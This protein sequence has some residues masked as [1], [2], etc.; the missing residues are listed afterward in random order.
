L[1]GIVPGDVVAVMLPN[2]AHFPLA[3][4]ALSKI[5][6]T[7]VPVNVFYKRA[8]AGYLLAHS[9]ARAVLTTEAHAPLLREIAADGG[10]APRI[11]T[12]DGTI[13]GSGQTLD[14]LARDESPTSFPTD[15]A[16]LANIQYTSG[17]TGH[18]KGCML[19]NG[20]WLTMARELVRYNRLSSEDTMLTAQPFYYMDPQWNVVCALLTGCELVVLDRFHP[21]E[22]WRK[23]RQHRV[24]WFYCLGTMPLMLLNNPPAPDD[25]D[26]RVRMVM[27]SAIPPGR[28][29]EIEQ[30]WGAPW[31]EA[32]GMT[33]TGGDLA[34]PIEEHDALV[35]S[36]CIGRPLP[37]REARIVGPD[38]AELPAD[39]VGEMALRGARMMN[40][41][42][43][44][45]E[46][47]REIMRGGW[48]HTGDLARRDAAGRFYY[49]GR[50]K[51]MIR[52]SGENI[53]AAEV[54]ETITC[55]PAVRLAACVAAPDEVR[56]EEVMAYVVLLPGR[57]AGPEEL[58][59][60]C[61]DR[62]AYFK[63][64]RYWTFRDDLPRTP[65][66][67]VAKGQ[68]RERTGDPRAGAYDRVD[69]VWR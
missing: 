18:P 60:H 48:L 64:P 66:E 55:H 53:S 7:M 24:S 69:A 30:R 15:A 25:R 43:K 47:T 11:L 41:Y 8:D 13:D 56:G 65:S 32:F 44:N 57:E 9:E 23:I 26:H 34:V 51:D 29:A 46:A 68:L 10:P 38:G 42:F 2:R 6:A 62:L 20:Y 58:T 36:G 35:G 1:L 14:A 59:A 19:S 37:H 67:R 61:R 21:T 31:Y 16:H 39:E 28:H 52:R 33:E 50:L 49:V 27:C 40:G 17:T 4:L 12:I 3:W 63:V 54:E 5:G 22:F 45:R